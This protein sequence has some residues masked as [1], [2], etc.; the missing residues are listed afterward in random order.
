MEQCAQSGVAGAASIVDFKPIQ[1]KTI[2]KY[3]R[4]AM[5]LA[6]A[7]IS[8]ILKEG[9]QPPVVPAVVN[10][11]NN[12]PAAAQPAAVLSEREQARQFGND[13]LGNFLRAVYA[14]A[15][16]LAQEPPVQA[17]P[18]APA[19]PVNVMEELMKVNYNPQLGEYV[20]KDGL[21]PMPVDEDTVLFYDKGKDLYFMYDTVNGNYYQP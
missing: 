12:A 3:Y 7:F 15:N 13:L 1:S 19:Q 17:A 2:Q 11:N 20:N 16:P 8:V 14:P 6:A 18:A 9:Q 10:N 4:R 5:N 21:K